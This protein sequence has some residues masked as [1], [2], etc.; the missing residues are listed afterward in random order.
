MIELIIPKTVSQIIINK[1]IELYRQQKKS[2]GKAYPRRQLLANIRS[3]LS[4]GGSYID[5]IN[6]KEPLVNKWKISK[7]KVYHYKH[8]YY[9]LKFMVDSYGNTIAVAQDALYE[10]DYHD[11]NIETKPYES[12]RRNGVPISEKRLK[13]IISESI[14]KVLYN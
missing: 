3:A 11:D 6:I 8:W 1:Y 9:A 10:G 14:R 12:I 4:C 2:L 5:E 13:Q 7:Y